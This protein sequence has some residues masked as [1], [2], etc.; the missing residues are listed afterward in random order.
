MPIVNWDDR[1]KVG[2]KEVDE[3]HQH[4][5][6]LLNKTY[7]YLT[8]AAPIEKLKEVV[9][10][11]DDYATYHFTCEEHWMLES[12]YPHFADHKREHETFREKIGELQRQGETEGHFSLTL[13]IFLINWFTTHI[14]STDS[15]YHHYVANNHSSNTVNIRL[16][17]R[18]IF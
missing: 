5:V 14:L 2:N 4:L 9:K 13:L 1:F 17:K 11:L 12:S 3:H 6:G 18:T 7:D 10:E 15:N 8:S 16:M